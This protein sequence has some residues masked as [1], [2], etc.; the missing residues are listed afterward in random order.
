MKKI[1]R[2]SM[3]NIKKHGRESILLT[4]LIFLC[5]TLLSSAVSAVKGIKLV[6]PSM[7]ENSG[8]YKNFIYIN[9]DKYSDRYLAFLENDPRVE[10]YD[11]TSMV[12]DLLKVRVGQDADTEKL[13]DIS[14]VPESG[15]RRMESFS[16]D[17]DFQ[18]VE[19][20]IVLASPNKE[21]L[22]ISVGDELTVIRNGKEFTFTVAGF[23]D[24]G[25]WAYG[26]KAVISEDDFASLE[27]YMAR[28]EVIG[29]NTVPG[30]DDDAL[31]KDF[32]AFAQDASIGDLT[33]AM[34][35]TTYKDMVDMNETN[36]ELLS[37]IIAILSGVIVIAVMIMIRFRIVSDLKE[38]ILSIGV[39]EALGYTSGEIA[40]SY[41]AEYMLLAL[42]G[43]VIGIVPSYFFAKVQLH[44]AASSV[45]YGGAV[46]VPVI[47]I[48]CCVIII[49]LFVGL[50]AMS[51][52]L[53]VR[54]YP[55]VL[56]FRKGIE[57][58]SFKKN[59]VPL[60]KTRGSVHV[61][62]A[63]K[64][65]LQGARNQIGLTVC[66]AACTVM[67]LLSFMI[68]SFFSS[69]DR[70]LG[71]VCGHE[72][73]DMRIE[74]TVDIDPEAFVAELESMPEVKKVLTP[75]VGIGVKINGNDNSV[76]LEVY[77]DYA[78]TSTILLT[79]G[80]LPEHDNE[81]A[82]AVQEKKGIGVE[83]GDTVT[84][85]YG[86]VKR[87]YLVTGCVNSAVDPMT[88]YL[89]TEGFKRMNPAYVPHTFDMYLNEG[90]DKNAFAD[91]LKGRYGKEIAQYKDGEVTGDTLEERIRSAANAKMAKAMTEKGV[92]YME[93][94]IQVGD[95]VITGS[96]SAMKIRKLTFVKEENQEIASMLCIS[97]AGISIGM[98]IASGVIVILML[99]ILMA[100]TIRKQYRELGILK[101]L[102]YTSRELMFQMA[103]R[104]IP[105][106]LIAVVIGTFLSIP[107]MGIVGA[108][109]CKI[110]VSV[111]G[112]LFMDLAILAFCFGCAYTCARRIK[113]I[114][115]YELITE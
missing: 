88:A 75:A 10:G 55:P 33:S 34:Y 99:A 62:L 37:I 30:T 68:G 12:T 96:T 65:F 70:I 97:F 3:A 5:I 83:V 105:V 35:L 61:R 13:F 93:Y 44:S 51:R 39:L 43:A 27:N 106:A 64:E 86:K 52:A 15:E 110:E 63:M 42:A 66:I 90:V 56:A 91:F 46:A 79:E 25:I 74:G 23:Y 24:C 36:M 2:L 100:S 76:G 1:L 71:S 107:L 14:F 104:I 11:H 19:H 98:M 48:L 78:K 69:A 45:N 58:H 16:A 59:L 67:V 82:L 95:Q 77:E 72:M 47:P 40:A 49:L 85:E 115:A 87:D 114:S 103:F 21:K 53:A 50:T 89:T 8:C 102:G 81:V 38:Q 7:V 80:R 92:S 18:S 101:S 54:K 32:R 112:I 20:P 6:M 4:I 57:T 109:V 22:E 17:I 31:L 108:F 9:Q 28:Y 73:C 94:S 29:I 84:I 26:T 113:K 41:V 60:E 111:M